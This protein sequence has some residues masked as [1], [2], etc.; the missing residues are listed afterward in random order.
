[1]VQGSSRPPFPK[2]GR[3]L[4]WLMRVGK[5][6]SALIRISSRHAIILHTIN[7]KKNIGTAP[8]REGGGRPSLGWAKGTRGSLPRDLA[9]SSMA[10]SVAKEASPAQI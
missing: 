9:A 1:M 8:L 6:P 7:D 2:E 4:P 10:Q 3:E 5:I